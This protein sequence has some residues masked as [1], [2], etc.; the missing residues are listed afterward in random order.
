MQRRPFKN[1]R[2]SP[3]SRATIMFPLRNTAI[4]PVAFNAAIFVAAGIFI[5][6]HSPTKIGKG[7]CDAQHAWVLQKA[8]DAIAGWQANAYRHQ[9]AVE[10]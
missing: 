2:I 7:Y 5:L 1:E 3:E 6:L 9:D 4:S 10:S 8:V